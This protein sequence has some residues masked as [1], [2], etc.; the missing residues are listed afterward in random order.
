MLTKRII[1]CLDIDRG[2][3]VKG[4]HFE[5]L[6]DAGDPVE[7]AR[8]YEADGADELPSH[9]RRERLRA[10]RSRLVAL[11][12]RA[13]GEPHRAI[14]ARLNRSVGARSVADATLEQ[15]ARANELLAREL[16][17]GG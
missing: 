6:R 13:S 7:V 15:L 12:S 2:R 14:N 1:P 4:I 3:V 16:A 9:E 11:R 8:R 17:A 5:Q 10:E